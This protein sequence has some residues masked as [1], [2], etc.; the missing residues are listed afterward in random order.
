MPEKMKPRGLHMPGVY[1][2]TVKVTELEKIAVPVKKIADAYEQEYPGVRWEIRRGLIIELA[3]TYIKV[4]WLPP[5]LVRHI[6][7]LILDTLRQKL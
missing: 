2:I 6:I 5:W 3:L 1:P 4:K 7:G